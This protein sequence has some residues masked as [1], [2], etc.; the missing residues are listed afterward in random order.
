[1]AYEER[2]IRPHV[3]LTGQNGNA[4]NLMGLC[5]RAAKKAGWSKEQIDAVMHEM[6]AGDYNHLL[7]TAMKHFEVH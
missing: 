1:M 6:M 7:Q 4:F 3:K 2:C 5:S